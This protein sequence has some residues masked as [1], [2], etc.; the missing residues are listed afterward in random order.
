MSDYFRPCCFLWGAL[1][2]KYGFSIGY[3]LSIL[4]SI[5]YDVISVSV[6]N[7]IIEMAGRPRGWMMTVPIQE[8]LTPLHIS[9]EEI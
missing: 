1:Q 6:K 8:L 9:N 4:H 7:E 5:I 2:I 3:Y